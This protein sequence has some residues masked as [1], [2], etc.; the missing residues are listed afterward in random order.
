MART[1]DYNEALRLG[2]ETLRG[3]NAKPIAE[4][5]DAGIV[6]HPDG[7]IHV[8]LP[9]LNREILISWPDFSFSLK[10]SDAKVPIQ[11][12]ILLLHYMEGAQGMEVEGA[13]IAYQ[14]VPDGRFYLDAFQRRAKVPMIQA[15]G[16]QPE[17]LLDLACRFYGARPL[18]QGDCS[19]LIKAAPLLPVALILWKGDDEF[20]PD[21][22]ILFDRSIVRILPAEDIAWLA[23]M[24]IY[25]LI[26]LLHRG[27][28]RVGPV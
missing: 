14:E 17:A 18:D 8:A 25:P 28:S 15:F 9:F 13:W 10:N 23:G 19:V 20:P 2:K 11:E 22:N 21:G 26:G 3:K 12:Q 27:E 24:I 4:G 1:D 6:M 16:T 5:C 7:S